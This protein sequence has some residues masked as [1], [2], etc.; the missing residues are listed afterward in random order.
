MCKYEDSFICGCVVVF[1]QH[2]YVYARREK[3]QSKRAKAKR[4]KETANFTIEMIFIS[5][6]YL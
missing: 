3:E 4:E 5:Q 2:T 1:T 6:C